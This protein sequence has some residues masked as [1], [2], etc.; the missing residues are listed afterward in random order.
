MTRVYQN[1]QAIRGGGGPLVNFLGVSLRV[2]DSTSTALADFNATRQREKHELEQLNDKLAQYVEK[3]KFL[4]IQNKKLQM[5]LDVLRNRAGQD[6]SRIKQMYDIERNEANKLIDST[7]YD[8]AAA[9]QQTEKEVEQ[10]RV[11]YNEVS[12]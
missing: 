12:N 1:F 9:A 2:P 11:Q 3:V 6:S 7:K 10:R 4:E 5:E 8:N